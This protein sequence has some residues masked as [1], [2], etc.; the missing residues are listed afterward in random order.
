M[1]S[2]AAV[3]RLTDD[4]VGRIEDFAEQ[5]HIPNI[6]FEGQERREDVG[7]GAGSPVNG[8]DV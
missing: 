5:H 7:P 3:R 1:A 2:I 4:F 6:K 8:S